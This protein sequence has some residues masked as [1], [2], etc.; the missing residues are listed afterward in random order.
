MHFDTITIFV[1]AA[2][3]LEGGEGFVLSHVSP[4]N[5]AVHGI[6]SLFSVER[7]ASVFVNEA[8]GLF[9][10][11]LFGNWIRSAV[12]RRVWEILLAFFTT[13]FVLFMKFFEGLK[14]SFSLT[15]VKLFRVAFLVHVGVRSK[16]L[17]KPFSVLP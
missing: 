3:E 2:D 10:S 7:L 12:G 14:S 9:R 11:W 13:L 8:K 16:E 4:L 15:L 17:V 6:E 5:E 1:E